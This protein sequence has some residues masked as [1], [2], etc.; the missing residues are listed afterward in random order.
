M[1]IHM[2][3]ISIWLKKFVRGWGLGLLTTLP[4]EIIQHSLCLWS[5]SE[6]KQTKDAKANL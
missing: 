4:L 2:L 6:Q 5:S 1:L 3:L